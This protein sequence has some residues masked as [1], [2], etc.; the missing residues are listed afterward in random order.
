MAALGRR[1]VTLLH[2]PDVE[3]P[4]DINGVA[5][6]PLDNDEWKLRLLGDLKTTGFDVHHEKL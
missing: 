4:S 1:N 5:Y 6:Y 3:I 2:D